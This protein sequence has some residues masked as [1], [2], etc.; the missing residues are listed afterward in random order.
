[1]GG[2]LLKYRPPIRTRWVISCHRVFKVDMAFWSNGVGGFGTTM[3]LSKIS[4]G[5]WYGVDDYE[6]MLGEPH[7]GTRVYVDTRRFLE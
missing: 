2:S 1:M 6:T 4:R 3:V 5:S 7:T